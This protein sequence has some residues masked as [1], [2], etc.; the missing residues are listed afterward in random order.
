MTLLVDIGNSRI[1]WALG[2]GEQISSSHAVM[3]EKSVVPD[4][5]AEKWQAID[6]PESVWLSSVT[7][8]LLVKRVRGFCRRT[9]KVPVREAVSE[10]ECAGLVNAYSEPERL[11]VDRW[12]ALLGAHH[13][14]R[15]PCVVADIGTAVTV[16]VISAEGRH[17]GGLIVPGQELAIGAVTGKTHRVRMDRDAALEPLGRDTTDALL[18]GVLQS[19]A[20]LIDR[21]VRR[22]QAR[23][24]TPPTVLVTGG[25]ADKIRPLLESA[26]R[27]EPD[28]V[29][30]GLARYAESRA[31]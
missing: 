23:L 20:A 26:S 5:L 2:D 24:S 4:T 31:Q 28:L 15:G 19:H 14:T 16:D 3:R 30:L 12:M 17:L 9:W 6:A 13:R 25:G 29:L 22:M 1:K 18:S 10:S 7:S 27:H 21:V 8:K 11:G